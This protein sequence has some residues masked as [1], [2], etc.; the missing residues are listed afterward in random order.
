MAFKQLKQKLIG[1]DIFSDILGQNVAKS[2]LK[3]ALLVDRH[4]I[5]EGAPGIGKTTLVK[6]IP[7]HLTEIEVVEG[8]SFHC[9]PK[10]PICPECLAKKDS[11]EKLI[12]KKIE[13]SKRFVRIQGSPDLTVEDLLGDIDPTKAI[14]FGPSSIEAFTPGKLFKANRGVLFFDEVNRCSEKLQNALLQVLEEGIATIGS[15]DLDLPTN[16]IFIGTMNP[17]D[18]SGTE[19][20]SDVFM[21]RF[22]VVKMNYPENKDIEVEILNRHAKKIDGVNFSENMLDILVSFVRSLRG[23]QK[24]ERV[25]SVRA[26]IGLYERSLANALIRGAKE[27]DFSDIKNSF[28]TVL[29]HRIKLKPSIKYLMSASEFINKELGSFLEQDP[30]YAKFSKFVTDSEK[31]SDCP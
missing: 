24:L 12:S 11:G 7:E 4:I 3:S 15:Y 23:S 14:K 17:E 28:D 10:N 6:S 29:S 8:C 19:T 2:M 1:E 22:D 16:F 31:E 20:L 5:I 13:G 21:D 26:S 9:D 18:S 30:D 25:P 27:V